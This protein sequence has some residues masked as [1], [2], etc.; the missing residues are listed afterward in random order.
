MNR[1]LRLA[2]PVCFATAAL[3]SGAASSAPPAPAIAKPVEPK[4]YVY[5]VVRNG[6]QIGRH[7]VVMTQTGPT[8]SID[9]ATDI[10][11]KVVFVTAYTL[12]T[13]SREVWTGDKFTSFNSTTNDN[14]TKHNVS[15]TVDPKGVNVVAD[16]KKTA[17]PAP[18]IPASFWNVAMLDRTSLFNTETGAPLEVKVAE[19]G[20]EMIPVRGVKKEAVHYKITG[21]IE[22]DAWFADGVPV[23]FQ[24]KGSDNSV[25]T[26]ELLPEGAPVVV[27]PGSV[28]G[29]SGTP[30][31]PAP[32]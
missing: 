31:A 4:T 14:G 6:T 26:S 19:V 25:I 30:K 11:V 23:R 1:S 16:G 7:S 9:S 20:R 10:A 18:T 29:A 32:R 21:T 24:L 17:M 3:F 12:Q 8:M 15:A 28:A 5:S 2:A 13:S 22:R 27:V